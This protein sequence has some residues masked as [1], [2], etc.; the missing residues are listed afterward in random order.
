MA[1]HLSLLLLALGCETEDPDDIYPSNPTEDMFRTKDAGGTNGAFDYCDGA[2]LCTQGEGDCDN[3]GQC[4]VGLTCVDD[5]GENFGLV[6]TYD[7]CAPAHCGNDAL[8]GD[9]TAIDFGGSCGNQCTL[10]NGHPLHC[11]PGCECSVGEGDCDSDADCDPGLICGDDNGTSFGLVWSTDVCVT[12]HCTNGVQDAD[13]TGIDQGGADCGGVC[14]GVNGDA[15]GYCTPGCPCARGE[16]DC[17]TDSECQAGL[18]CVLDQGDHFGLD[19]SVDTCVDT[20]AVSEL[21]AGDLQITEVM[22]NPLAVADSGGEWFEI[23]NASGV[24]ID[25][26]GLRVT[27]AANGGAFTVGVQLII[28]PDEHMVF[29]RTNNPV[30]NGGIPWHYDYLNTYALVDTIDRIILKTSVNG[31]VIDEVAWNATWPKPNGASIQLGKQYYLSDNNVST[32]WCASTSVMS[33]GDFGTPEAAN[34]ICH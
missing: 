33:D 10:P 31:A 26:N 13:E 9:E 5:I 11:H 28:A 14:G 23:R 32:N 30:T 8:D 17:D 7:V 21:V 29:A 2:T 25:L 6:W 18:T 34:K 19:A 15:E 20:Y 4:D 16:G 3:A 27:D 1:A 22:I 24:T 12:N